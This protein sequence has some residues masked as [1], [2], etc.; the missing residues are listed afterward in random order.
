MFNEPGK[1]IAG[2]SI[3]GFFTISDNVTKGSYKLCNIA[4]I[5]MSGLL[6]GKL[7]QVWPDLHA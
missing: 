4:V 5:M 3:K 7:M 2:N 1:K 6:C